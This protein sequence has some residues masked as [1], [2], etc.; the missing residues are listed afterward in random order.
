MELAGKDAK[1][2]NESVE[3]MMDPMRTKSVQRP[4]P[5]SVR[6]LGARDLELR[7]NQKG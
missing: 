4:W 1:N 5:I 2:N 3:V 7:T 6:Y